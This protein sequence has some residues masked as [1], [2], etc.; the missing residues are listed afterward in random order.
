[1]SA[2]PE[3]VSIGPY[4]GTA[5]LL[6]KYGLHTKTYPFDWIYST[7]AVVRHCIQDDFKIFLD[8][9]YYKEGPEPDKTIH[10]YYS[11]KYMESSVLRAHFSKN[12]AIYNPAVIHIFNHHTMKYNITH[13][14]SFQRHIHRFK[15]LMKS[16]QPIVFVYY[17][18]HTTSYDDLVEFY[19][20]MSTHPSIHVLGLFE[21]DG[22]EKKIL[23]D[24]ERCRIYQNYDPADAFREAGSWATI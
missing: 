15:T 22:G 21:T 11:G 14:E 6:Q 7:L 1:M 13:Y 2:P 23:F 17:N 20:D 3:F 19:K 24:E 18:C 4:C 5:L 12:N 8:K 9:S 16:G 10:T